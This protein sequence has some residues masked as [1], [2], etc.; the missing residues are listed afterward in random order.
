M[1]SSRP[2]IARRARKSAAET[3]RAIGTSTARINRQSGPRTAATASRPAPASGAHGPAAGPPGRPSAPAARARR[4]VSRPRPWS[5]PRARG[6]GRGRATAASRHPFDAAAA[7]RGGRAGSP[8]DASAARR[9]LSSGPWPL[10][11]PACGPRPRPAPG[12]RL[13]PW[14]RTLASSARAFSSPGPWSRPDHLC[15]LG[16]GVPGLLLTPAPCEKSLSGAHHALAIIARRSRSR[17]EN[18]ARTRAIAASME[19]DDDIG[20]GRVI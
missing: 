4:R 14:P 13:S 12:R 16:Q 2:P 6:S 5:T 3:K 10:P 9:G 17:P 20:A 19:N 18:R 11:S 7:V 15:L 1:A 8:G